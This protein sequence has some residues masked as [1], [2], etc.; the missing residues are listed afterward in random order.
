MQIRF[1]ERTPSNQTM[2]LPFISNR[3]LR[4]WRRR[5]R[6]NRRTGHNR[7]VVAPLAA[8][9]SAARAE[10]PSRPAQASGGRRGCRAPRRPLS[11]A[12][13]GGEHGDDAEVVASPAARWGTA[14]TK[15]SLVTRAAAQGRTPSPHAQQLRNDTGAALLPTSSKVWAR[16]SVDLCEE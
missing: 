11:G 14:R 3:L 10:G 15:G 12:N 2:A 5:H 16:A 4:R 8:R 6:R 13:A 1:L 9:W 7:G